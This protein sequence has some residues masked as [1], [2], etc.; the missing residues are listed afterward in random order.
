MTG[1]RACDLAPQVEAALAALP[2][3]AVTGLRQSGKTTFLRSQ[4]EMAGR[5]YVTLDDFATLD[6]AR[7][8]P[9]GFVSGGEPLTIDEAQRCPELLLAIKRAVDSD[10]RPGRFLLSGS[11][12]FALLRDLS[13]SLASIVRAG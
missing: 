5:R 10:R 2:V 8:D 3:V 9:D 6:A 12:N 7:R 11:A 1:Y 13:E 4:P